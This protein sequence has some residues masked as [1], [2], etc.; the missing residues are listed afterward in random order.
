[1]IATRWI[2]CAGYPFSLRKR[3]IVVDVRPAL[4][5]SLPFMW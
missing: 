2:T 4:K 1:M 5:K 3:F